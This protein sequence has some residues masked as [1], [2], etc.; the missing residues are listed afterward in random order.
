MPLKSHLFMSLRTLTIVTLLL[1]VF[2]QAHSQKNY[3][4]YNRIGF[5][6]GFALFDIISSDLVTKQGTG[7]EGGFTTRGGFRN[8]F[9][10][11]YGISFFNSLIGVQ[12]S[13]LNDT[14]FIQY[15]IQAAQLGLL[16]SYNIVMNHLSLE[17]GP[18]LHVN[19]KMNL[20]NDTYEDYILEGYTALKAKDI[21][22]I[23]RINFRVAGGITAG[24]EQVRASVQYQ[25]GVTNILGRLNDEEKGFE[26][27]DFKGNSSTIVLSAVFYF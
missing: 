21:Q 20:N 1:L 25:Y 19:G 22:D 14:Q 12:G 10:L 13:S 26:K 8:N 17:F 9:D 3:D 11:I 7:F 16:G 27:K 6:G 15:Q 5:T 18:L 23:N 4:G 2:Q 24:V